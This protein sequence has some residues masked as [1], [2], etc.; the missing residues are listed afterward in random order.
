MPLA[1][2]SSLSAYVVALGKA[3]VFVAT[4]P[5]ST[6][7]WQL[8]GITEGDIG[9]DEKHQYNDFKLPEWTGDAIH[10]RTI[11]GS[12]IMATIP[13]IWGNAELYDAIAPNGVKGG[14][15]SVPQAV[16]TK[17]VVIIPLTEVGDG[18]TYN[19]TTWDPG[20]P[21]HA[22]WLHKATFEPGAYAFKHGD[23]GK[24]IRQVG[25]RPMFDD[26]K[27]EG[28]KLYTIGD[29]TVQGITTYRM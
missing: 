3:Y 29:P 28:Q 20:A 24:V 27:P 18:L 6:T 14:G 25:I 7:S 11:D 1:P 9:V 19:G 17:T 22:I 5:T 8:L 12:D 16:A 2:V 21:V 23:G 26:T 10:A 4:D 15:F 13:L